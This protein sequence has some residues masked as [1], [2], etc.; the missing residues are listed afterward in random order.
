MANLRPDF[1]RPLTMAVAVG[2]LLV[3]CTP[4][5]EIPR[6]L[7]D[8]A[9]VADDDV[10]AFVDASDVELAV[11]APLREPSR[12]GTPPETTTTREGDVLADGGTSERRPDGALADDE[13]PTERESDEAMPEDSP[14]AHRVPLPMDRPRLPGMAMCSVGTEAAG[15]SWG[16]LAEDASEAFDRYT[17]WHDQYL[18]SRRLDG[19]PA[20]WDAG[21][22]TIVVLDD[23]AVFALS[24]KVEDPPLG[25][26][27]DPS[28]YIEERAADLAGRAIR[29]MP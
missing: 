6:G 29:R 1:L 21:L 26:D 24:L 27:E 10:C 9:P 17:A 25:E 5:V 20:M 22:Q 14:Q 23:N 12:A 19:R 3:A 13:S 15:A 28:G 11:N 7:G 2:T 16:V 8:P 4:T 18:D